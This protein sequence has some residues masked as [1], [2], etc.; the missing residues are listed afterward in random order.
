MTFHDLLSPCRPSA[1]LCPQVSKDADKLRTRLESKDELA[2]T[3]QADNDQLQ[4]KLEEPLSHARD[5]HLPAMSPYPCPPIVRP[6]HLTAFDATW[7]VKLEE[8]LSE[9]GRKE[10]ALTVARSQALEEKQKVIEL[11][12][13]VAWLTEAKG[14]FEGMVT[15][16]DAEIHELNMR[17]TTAENAAKMLAQKLNNL[18]AKDAEA[19]L[20]LR[21]LKEAQQQAG[22]FDPLAQLPNV[23]VLGNLC[24]V[25]GKAEGDIKALTAAGGQLAS[26]AQVDVL[27]I[28]QTLPPDEGQ[29]YSKEPVPL[30]Y[31][32]VLMRQ[33][34]N[35]PAR[36]PP[37]SD[38]LLSPSMACV[39]VQFEPPPEDLPP[40]SP[41]PPEESGVFTGKK[42]ESGAGQVVLP[43]ES[44]RPSSRQRPDQS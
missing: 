11:E 1:V 18:G 10:R 42:A 19:S 25:I 4:V 44:G 6:P 8:L 7:Q 31:P 33:V 16:R 13:N 24:D 29:L 5:P 9:S 12:Q 27:K 20:E 2:R 35:L 40:P 38:G 3:A 17:A 41:P 30:P 22:V 34:C 14:R 43:P 39:L 36:S 28:D 21:P 32:P 37:S 23:P 26:M 15:K